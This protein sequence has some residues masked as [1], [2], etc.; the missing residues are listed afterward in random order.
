MRLKDIQTQPVP[1]SDWESLHVMSLTELQDIVQ[2]TNR[3][4]KNWGSESPRHVHI[5]TI[6]IAAGHWIDIC[7]V[8]PGANLVLAY[9]HFYGGSQMSCWDT[10]TCKRAASL[11]IPGIN[12][13]TQVFSESIGKAVLGGFIPYVADF[14]KF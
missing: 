13:R 14:R 8:V 9:S 5:D 3:L 12:V 2:R 4:M 6:A 10:I 1:V 7:L 11:E